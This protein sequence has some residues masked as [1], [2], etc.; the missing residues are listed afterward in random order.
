MAV[1]CVAAIALLFNHKSVLSLYGRI[2]LLALT[3]FMLQNVFQ[4]FLVTAE[5]PTFGLIITVAAGL[6][7]MLL[8]WLFIAVFR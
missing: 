4:S 7:N 2:I 6:T 3:A 8:D 5:K 1:T